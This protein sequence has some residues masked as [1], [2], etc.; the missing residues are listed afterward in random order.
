MCHWP[1]ISHS[2]SFFFCHKY[3]DNILPVFS[4][5]HI[6]RKTEWDTECRITSRIT[7][8]HSGS[9]LSLLFIDLG[10]KA[11]ETY[12]SQLWRLEPKIRVPAGVSSGEDSSLSCRLIVSSSHCTSHDTERRS[13]CTFILFRGLHSHGPITSQGLPLQVPSYWA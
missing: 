1:S 4:L 12:C 3:I 7:L 2:L 11:T 5:L 8:L 13:S 9:D 6:H 10:S